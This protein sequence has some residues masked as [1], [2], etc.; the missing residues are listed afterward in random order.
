MAWDALIIQTPTHSVSL[1]LLPV[2]VFLHVQICQSQLQVLKLQG[3]DMKREVVLTS[4]DYFKGQFW[5]R[6]KIRFRIRLR[7]G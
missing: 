5:C 7:I 6:V 4:P 1:S 2:C 3:E